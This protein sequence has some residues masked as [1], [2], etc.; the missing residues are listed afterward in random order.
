MLKYCSILLNVSSKLIR[1]NTFLKTVKAS[2]LMLYFELT[3]IPSSL[4]SYSLSMKASTIN[5][6]LQSIR[7]S[8]TMT[9]KGVLVSDQYYTAGQAMTKL[10]L[11]KAMF[12]RKVNQGLIPKV[13]PPGKKQSVYPKRDI[14]A[15]RCFVFPLLFLTNC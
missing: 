9:I 1:F 2:F 5:K 10:G 14:D 3:T 7:K 15:L 8:S 12:H 11:S 4:Y 6:S 13:T